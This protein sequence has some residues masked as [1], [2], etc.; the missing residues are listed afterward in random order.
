ML[1]FTNAKRERMEHSSKALYEN[2]TQNAFLFHFV[3]K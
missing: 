1:E 3:F 2:K